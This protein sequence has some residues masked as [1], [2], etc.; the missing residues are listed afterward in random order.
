MAIEDI[1][2]KERLRRFGIRVDKVLW[3]DG[4]Y[5]G[6]KLSRNNVDLTG[7]TCFDFGLDLTRLLEAEPKDIGDAEI[8]IALQ[9]VIENFNQLN[10][11]K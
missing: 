3:P 9:K 6:I 5:R 11:V 1:P 4:S 8:Q 10:G 2:L 7:L